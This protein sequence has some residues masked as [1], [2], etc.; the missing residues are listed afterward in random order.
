MHQDLQNN[1]TYI[2]QTYLV[3]IAGLSHWQPHIRFKLEKEISNQM[4]LKKLNMSYTSLTTTRLHLC[5]EVFSGSLYFI[6]SFIV[7]LPFFKIFN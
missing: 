7:L 5:Y 1:Y 6:L 2:N 3:N 4:T